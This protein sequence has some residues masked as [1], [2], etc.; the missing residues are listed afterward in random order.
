MANQNRSVIGQCDDL[1]FRTTQINAYPHV[2]HP[3]SSGALGIVAIAGR[4]LWYGGD[5]PSR[6]RKLLQA[7]SVA[8]GL[9]FHTPPEA[10]HPS[11]ASQ[12]SL[13]SLSLHYHSPEHAP[14]IGRVRCTIRP[15]SLGAYRCGLGITTCVPL[16]P[17]IEIIGFK[18]GIQ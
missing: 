4:L 3:E 17:A 1:Y 12:S 10:F 9:T 2:I 8:P 5:P 16:V 18:I 6:A 11:T 14:H 13:F 15:S 7:H